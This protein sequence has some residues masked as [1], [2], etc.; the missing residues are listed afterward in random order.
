MFLY[1]VYLTFLDFDDM[2]NIVT[3]WSMAKDGAW[4]GN[5]IH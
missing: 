1:L 4:I 3:R 2:N 5:R